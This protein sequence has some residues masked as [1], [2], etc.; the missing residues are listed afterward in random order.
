MAIQVIQR[1]PG[2]GANLGRA[3]G[4]GGA[5]GFTQGLQNAKQAQ[6]LSSILGISPQEALSYGG[7]DPQV[8]KEV[9]KG[10]RLKAE[11][12]A[13]NEALN[14]F[15]EYKAG[16]DISGNQFSDRQE[17]PPSLEEKIY[18]DKKTKAPSLSQ[19]LNLITESKLKNLYPTA[20]PQENQFAVQQEASPEFGE[21]I[22]K[23]IPRAQK[24]KSELQ[25]FRDFIRQKKINLTPAQRKEAESQIMEQEKLAEE[26]KKNAQAETRKYRDKVNEEYEASR[27]QLQDLERLDELNKAGKLDDAAWTTFLEESGLNIPALLDPNSQ[28]F[29]KTALGF[30]RSGRSI[31]GSRLTDFDVRQLLQMI[32]TLSQSPKGRGRIIATLRR[33]ARGKELNYKAMRDIMRENKGIPPDDMREQINDRI[34]GPLN[35]L[36]KKFKK[37][38]NEMEKLLPEGSSKAAIIGSALGGKLTKGVGRALEIAPSTAAGA[39]IGSYLAPGLGT[40]GGAGLGALYALLNNPQQP[41]Q[42]YPTQLLLP[43]P[44]D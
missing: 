42:S 8:L 19:M 3:L 5:Q 44:T 24:E 27:D 26:R 9:I 33:L 32:P 43:P 22:E 6:A 35:D 2:L 21:S 30:L 34:K 39:L 1:G 25:K 40:L 18:P 17:A 15:E 29:Q 20:V 23:E 37:E 13:F 11:G 41:Q 36:Y 16:G 14:A 12:D 28:E 31:F 38:L 10:K 7:L 4:L